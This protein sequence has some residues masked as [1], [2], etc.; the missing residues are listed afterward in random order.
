[1]SRQTLASGMIPNDSEGAHLRQWI[2]DPQVIKPG[3]LMPSFSLSDRQ[4]DLIVAY[5]R[6]LN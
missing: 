5:L 3:C 2:A 1:M 6:G 4:L